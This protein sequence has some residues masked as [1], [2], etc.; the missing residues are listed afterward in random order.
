MDKQ[1]TAPGQ[2]DKD[3]ASVKVLPIGELLDRI[4]Q[5]STCIAN[6]AFELFAARGRAFGRDLDDWLRAESEFVRPIRID[7]TESADAL[8][9]RAEVPGFSAN[10]LEVGVESHRL[11]ISGKHE[12]TEQRP[13]EKTIYGGQGSNQIYR[14][15]DLPADIDTSKVTATLKNGVL[16]LTM[17]KAAKAQKVPVQENP[18]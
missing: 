9:V 6:R 12:P 2:S 7:L 16:T 13:G 15:I 3:A 5:M 1:S 17:P 14:A 8:T 10:E 4:Q 18:N 11:T